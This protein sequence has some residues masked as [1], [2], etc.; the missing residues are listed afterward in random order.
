[1]SNILVTSAN[2]QLGSE[3]RVL[4]NER[5]LDTIFR[6]SKSLELTHIYYFHSFF[7]IY[8]VKVIMMIKEG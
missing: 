1:M 2:G 4:A 3:I 6:S 7:S 8:L 5:V